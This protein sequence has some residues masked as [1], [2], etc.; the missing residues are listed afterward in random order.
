M[1][2]FENEK[3]FK[4]VEKLKNSVPTTIKVT[5][6]VEK[7]ENETDLDLPMNLFEA[8]KEDKVEHVSVVS[9]KDLVKDFEDVNFE[10]LMNWFE[11]KEEVKFKESEKDQVEAEIIED[12]SFENMVQV[13]E[14]DEPVEKNFEEARKEKASDLGRMK[15]DLDLCKQENSLEIERKNSENF[16]KVLDPVIEQNVKEKRKEKASELSGM[17]VDYEF[18]DQNVLEIKSENFVN[19]EKESVIL[20]EII[21]KES[22]TEVEN[23]SISSDQKFKVLNLP[24]T[25]KRKMVFLMEEKKIL[26]KSIK[27]KGN[28]KKNL[29]SNETKQLEEYSYSDKYSVLKKINSK[30]KLLKV[31]VLNKINAKMK[32]KAKKQEKFGWKKRKIKGRFFHGVRRRLDLKKLIT[33]IRASN[34]FPNFAK[35]KRRFMTNLRPKKDL[36][37]GPETK[38]DNQTF[39]MA[40]LFPKRTMWPTKRENLKPVSATWGFE[41]ISD[42]MYR[43]KRFTF[44]LTLATPSLFG[45]AVTAR[46]LRKSDVEDAVI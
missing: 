40:V 41:G 8:K 42:T 1:K 37:S 29:K 14:E 13:S 33:L 17:K 32:R 35:E 46:I 23:L 31:S 2:L 30:M 18:I 19:F 15:I 4:L 5:N 9:N 21:G 22:L 16:E 38:Q 28:F 7:C 45:S 25:R 34:Q 10:L 6:L 44:G 36:H 26:K 39:Q 3:E 27:K 43:L 20:K 11:E 24:K 12:I